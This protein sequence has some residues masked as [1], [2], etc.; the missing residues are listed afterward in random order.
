MD[1][2]YDLC[3]KLFFTK[4][5]HTSIY[6]F[7]S[8]KAPFL[9]GLIKFLCLFLV[10]GHLF[11]L[12]KF[13]ANVANVVVE[14]NLSDTGRRRS[15]RRRRVVLTHASFLD[16]CPLPACCGRKSQFLLSTISNQSISKSKR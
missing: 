7:I 13:I 11:F 5:K 12:A 1:D 15:R 2:C 9:L 8:T 4:A 16:K 3:C 10:I 14:H 6:K